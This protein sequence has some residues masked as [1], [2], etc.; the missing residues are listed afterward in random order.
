MTVLEY[1]YSDSEPVVKLDRNDLNHF[2]L[3]M[4]RRMKPEEA[5]K[6][7]VSELK[8]FT[9]DIK[10][11]KF[12][13]D[14]NGLIPP[15]AKF[16][17]EVYPDDTSY[18]GFQI[19][20]FIE[21]LNLFSGS[22]KKCIVVSA[23]T[24]SGKSKVFIA[25]AIFEAIAKGER[26]ILVYPRLSLMED[27]FSNILEIWAHL[28]DKKFTIGIQRGGIG[29]SDYITIKYGVSGE[30]SFLESEIINEFQGVSI[31]NV[32]CPICN[33]TIWA[34]TAPIGMDQKEIGK[35][36]CLSNNC[37][38]RDVDIFVSKEKIL[39]KKPNLLITTIDSLNALLFKQEFG[40]YIESCK[41]IV[42]DEAHSYES[43]NGAHAANLIKRLRALNPKL[44][45]FLASAT[46]PNP[47][48]FAA[49]LTGYHLKE[50]QLVE[51]STTELTPSGQEEYRILKLSDGRVGTSS[52][53]IQLLLMLS[54][55]VNINSNPSREKILTFLDSRDLVNRLFFDFLDADRKR[56]L[57]NFRIEKETYITSDK[58]KCP[59]GTE[60]KCDRQTC[61]LVGNPYY[62]GECWYGL[63]KSYF[64]TN[65]KPKTSQ[66]KIARV[67]S[68]ISEPIH[69]VDLIL[70]TSSMELGVDDRSINTVV[71]YKAPPSIYSFI[72]RKG[73]GGRDRNSNLTNIWVVTGTESTDRFYYNNLDSM[74]SQPYHIP[75]NPQN[76]YAVWVSGVLKFAH[77]RL[78]EEIDEMLSG[79]Q[80]NDNDYSLEFSAI[81][82]VA[83]KYFFS[84]SFCD[85]LKQLGINSSGLT[86]KYKKDTFK[87]L[88]DNELERNSK[89]LKI[90]TKSN[91]DIFDSIAQKCHITS[92]SEDCDNHIKTLQESLQ[93]GDTASYKDAYLKLSGLF[94]QAQFAP[95]TSDDANRVLGLLTSVPD[96]LK[97]K[98]AVNRNRVIVYENKAYAQFKGSLQ[99]SDPYYALLPMI[100]ASYNWIQGHREDA[101]TVK[102]PG[103][104]KYLM[105]LNLFSAGDTISLDVE[106][107]DYGDTNFHDFIF[108]YLPHRLS[109]YSVQDGSKRSR[110]T[111]RYMLNSRSRDE[112]EKVLVLNVRTNKASGVDRTY[113]Y[114][115]GTGT[116]IEPTSLSLSEI[117]T[118]S[119]ND[120]VKFCG[121][122]Y[123][124]FGD[125]DEKCSYH[126]L[127]LERGKMSSRGLYRY[128]L[129]DQIDAHKNEIYGLVKKYYNLYLLLEG[130]DLTVTPQ[131]YKRRYVKIN[132]AEPFGKEI[133][134]IPVIEINVKP[135]S[136]S[137][138]EQLKNIYITKGKEEFSWEDYLHSVSH[139]FV[140]LV[141]FISGVN[142]E[143]ITY[144]I[145]PAKSVI[146]IFELAETDTGVIDS[147][148]DSISSDPYNLMELLQALSKCTTHETDIQLNNV[149]T[150]TGNN[151][152]LSRVK[153][154]RQNLDALAVTDQIID[155]SINTYLEWLKN[156]QVNKFDALNKVKRLG[157]IISCVD[158]CPDC[159]QLNNCHDKQDQEISVSRTAVEIYVS[160]L[161]KEINLFEFRNG[162][163]AEKLVHRDGLIY[164]RR[165]DNIIWFEF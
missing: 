9:R 148:F 129:G 145:D 92:N 140:K 43:I 147:F 111:L 46:I 94:Q 5:G 128:V 26:T 156:P 117:E 3:H 159:V 150:I 141:S 45:V 66:I 56:K 135:L 12:D 137:S 78:Q 105:P 139:L 81:Y 18:A 27:Q 24:S 83:E 101:S 103:G 30:A 121:Y 134:Q 29:S 96:L 72:Q 132:F 37:K 38:L 110:L 32:K 82:K 7:L 44:N 131:N 112:N 35:F 126:N 130:E 49:K 155:S 104:I 17:K 68:S 79:G 61:S 73:R 28:S 20:G 127:N 164:G 2:A 42:F 4:R 13:F 1:F 59:M 48:D 71:Q 107:E 123:N 52:V 87:R 60:K 15:F 19:R 122:C 64:G 109:Y 133:A 74:L 158:G 153:A 144:H 80:A 31:R 70:S 21:T 65:M 63:T 154:R 113:A 51:P 23:P 165:K 75:L 8:L 95:E 85:K 115:T 76:L 146:R 11:V 151:L 22:K 98:E 39:R 54:H 33:S 55:S 86:S 10:R 143:Y 97:M 69:N 149:S 119:E 138:N 25:P 36:K 99:Y 162:N 93:S 34:P 67:M 50:I 102:F 89:S 108:R 125:E 160:T 53:L 116:F 57:A 84:K 47:V 62:D 58:Y 157:N 120:E 163:Y 14:T 77:E 161:Y 16:L 90:L 100:R 40:D 118:S 88:L 114:K 106:R 91:D 41:L 142:T 6:G 136:V 152:L 124:V